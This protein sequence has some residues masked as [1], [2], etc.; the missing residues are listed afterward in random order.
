[1]NFLHLCASKRLKRITEYAGKVKENQSETR[2]LM[3][4]I[5]QI[6]EFLFD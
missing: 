6:R 3:L 5:D 2:Y 4:E 1:M